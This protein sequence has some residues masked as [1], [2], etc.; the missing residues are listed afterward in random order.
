MQTFIL[1]RGRIDRTPTQQQL[2]PTTMFIDFYNRGIVF[3]Q[4]G[5]CLSGPR[6]YVLSTGVLTDIEIF[7]SYIW[8]DDFFQPVIQTSYGLDAPSP[9]ERRPY[10][11][12]SY[13]VISDSSFTVT[14]LVKLQR[15]VRKRLNASAWRVINSVA[16][17]C[18]LKGY[19]FESHLNI[20][21]SETIFDII[22]YAPSQKHVVEP[23]YWRWIEITPRRVAQ[24]GTGAYF[25][26]LLSIMIAVRDDLSNAVWQPIWLTQAANT[27]RVHLRREAVGSSQHIGT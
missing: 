25:P 11:F 1:W 24:R 19:S 16:K 12:F 26:A 17:G 20:L 15:I 13:E 18:A 2:M 21:Q 3:G 10:H 6:L 8:D 27:D 9:G 5:G 22:A 7:L 14:R 23:V 4:D